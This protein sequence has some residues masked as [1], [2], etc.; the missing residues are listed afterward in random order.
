MDNQESLPTKICELCKLNFSKSL[1]G[2]IKISTFLGKS[3][4]VLAH[5]FKELCLKSQ[6]DL[7]FL[8]CA[9]NVDTTLILPNSENSHQEV[10]TG[11]LKR[12][13]QEIILIIEENP[14][15]NKSFNSS[16]KEVVE[17][18]SNKI[19]VLEIEGQSSQEVKDKN[20]IETSIAQKKK[21]SKISRPK[22]KNIKVSEEEQIDSFPDVESIKI[23]E[24]GKV[25]YKKKCPKCGILQI[26]LKQHYL[27]HSQIKRYECKY[28]EKKFSQIGNYKTHLNL[29]TG[30]RPHVCQLCSNSFSDPN[31][32]RVHMIRHSGEKKYKCGLCSKSFGYAHTLTVHKLSHSQI[33]NFEVIS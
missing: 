19:S 30:K 32:L 16:Q 29:H 21:Q 11:L 6:N 26:N 22:R 20:S 23:I 33:R 4:L 7:K 27:V 28:C 18:D 8:N 31:S 3:K 13:D 10:I 9:N 1:L 5:H 12:T 17:E 15:L 2:V 14:N 25:K 24:D